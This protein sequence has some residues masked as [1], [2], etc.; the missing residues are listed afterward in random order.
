MGTI[1]KE[2]QVG[3]MSCGHCEM[4]VKKSLMAITGVI[5][6]RADHAANKVVVEANENADQEEFKKAIVKAGYTVTG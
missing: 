2:F 4:A 1:T 3:G 6:A 5:D